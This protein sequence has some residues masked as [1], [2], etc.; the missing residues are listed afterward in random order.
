MTQSVVALL[1]LEAEAAPSP[2]VEPSPQG[3]AASS[4][5]GPIV[6]ATEFG[7]VSSAAE[8]VAIR[9]AFEAGVPLVIVHAIEPSR[10]RLPG[11]RFR[12][13]I[14]QARAAREH[15]TNAIDRRVR[16]GGVRP[17][18]LV[19]EGDPATC[20]LDAAR[21]EGASRIVVGSHGRG[22]L[23][24]ALVGSVSADIAAH[25]DCP[26]DVV[27]GDG[28]ADVDGVGERG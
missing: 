20:V 10:L 3:L 8:R 12:E 28:G 7:T 21:A 16:A 22:R 1:R 14:D 11:G 17:Q 26:V 13:R 2:A 18:I 19:W 25:A 6:L 15:D 27:R 24:R 4:R 23:G 9:L 5:A